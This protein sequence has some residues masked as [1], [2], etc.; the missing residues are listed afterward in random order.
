MKI[1]KKSVWCMIS[2][3][4]ALLTLIFA[5]GGNVASQYDT[6]IN[7]FFNTKNYDIIQSE[8]GE[9]FND[10]KSDFLNDDGSF[11]DKAMRN[12]SLKVALQTA[13]EGTVLLKNKN[14][15]LPLEKDS[16]VSFFGISTAKY[17]LSGA[18]SGHLGVSVTT[19]ITEACKDNG[20]IVNP[21]LANAYKILS[22]KYGN[23]LTDPGKTISGSTMSDKCYI[24]YGINEA[25]WD[26]INKTT[27]GN[28]ENTFKDYGEAAFLLIS[29][30][31]GE[32]GDTNYKTPECI[33]NNYLDLAFE[34]QKI[35]DNLMD[36]KNKGTFKK[37]ILLI[38]SASPMQM[39]NSK[40]AII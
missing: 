9:P 22:S 4:F 29:R 40:N 26:Q 5:V 25:P 32:D 39:K 31:D 24:E 2:I 15:A 38:N 28:V 18:G 17:I 35:L 10:Y 27:I 1:F 12:N 11:N 13:T 19:N 21:S 30:N 36:L 34:E 33:D 3:F 23:Y 7:Q 37:V 20:I 14:N 8:E 6:Y 16:K